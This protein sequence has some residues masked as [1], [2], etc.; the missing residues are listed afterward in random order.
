ME[1]DKFKGQYW[2]QT[3]ITDWW[4]LSKCKEVTSLGPVSISIH[5][6]PAK[7][8]FFPFLLSI[9][10]Q[11][12]SSVHF[13]VTQELVK[14]E[15]DTPEPGN[16]TGLLPAGQLPAQPERYYGSPSSALFMHCVYAHCI[17]QGLSA[18]CL[19]TQPKQQAKE[20]A[21]NGKEPLK[22]TDRGIHSKQLT[23]PC[24]HTRSGTMIQKEINQRRDN[25]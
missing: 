17:P 1:A 8:L 7:P 2:N 22:E 23:K 13:F 10:Q 16:I 9:A 19:C 11:L 21:H 20:L 5:C 15:K 18:L 14:K 12:T 24:R 25:H 6:H 3:L 4:F